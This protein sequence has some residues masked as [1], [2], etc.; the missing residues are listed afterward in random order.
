MILAQRENGSLVAAVPETA[1]ALRPNIPSFDEEVLTLGRDEGE[2]GDIY[3][4][5]SD[6]GK[7]TGGEVSRGCPGSTA[8]SKHAL[9]TISAANKASKFPAD[10]SQRDAA[11]RGKSFH[12]SFGFSLLVQIQA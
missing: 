11:S 6:V 9:M 2:G 3:Q 7:R 8:N 5:I 12:V 4:C 10:I 1:G